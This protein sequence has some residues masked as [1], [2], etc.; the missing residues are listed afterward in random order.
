MHT[1]GTGCMW[2]SV[3]TLLSLLYVVLLCQRGFYI[4]RNI[5]IN[6]IK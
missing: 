6:E 2:K 5:K 4:D 1:R 3:F